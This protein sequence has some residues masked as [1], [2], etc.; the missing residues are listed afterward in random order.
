[1]PS[2]RSEK[3]ARIFE[4]IF[5]LKN[6]AVPSSPGIYSLGL[7]ATPETLNYQ[8]K[9]IPALG[10]EIYRYSFGTPSAP[11]SSIISPYSISGWT[12]AKTNTGI[13]RS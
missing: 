6:P 8:E 3:N 7:S 5:N 12:S 10:P 11:G 9:I 1:M 4:F 2:I 13:M